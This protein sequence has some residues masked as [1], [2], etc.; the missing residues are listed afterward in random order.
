MSIKI[1]GAGKGGCGKTS[2]HRLVIRYLKK[3]RKNS[4]SGS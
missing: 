3:E 1:G 2:N 4:D